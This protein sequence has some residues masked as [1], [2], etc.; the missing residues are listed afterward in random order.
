MNAATIKIGFG[1]WPMSGL[2]DFW[3]TPK[4][5]RYTEKFLLKW[6]SKMDKSPP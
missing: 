1:D 5:L 2:I 4:R 6:V 3:T